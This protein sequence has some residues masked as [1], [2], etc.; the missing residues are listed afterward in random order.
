MS[1]RPVTARLRFRCSLSLTLDVMFRD[2]RGSA[3]TRLFIAGAVAEIASISGQSLREVEL[4]QTRTISAGPQSLRCR[5][6]RSRGD[7]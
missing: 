4:F 5:E 2:F 1:G 7:P 3:V 6:Q